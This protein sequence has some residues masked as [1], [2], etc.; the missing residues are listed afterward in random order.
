VES[1][2]EYK[3]SGALQKL[4]LERRPVI[5]YA[6][7]H[8]EGWGYQVDDAVRTYSKITSLIR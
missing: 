3:F 7:G 4:T 2:L 1:S 6:L 5:G 8:G